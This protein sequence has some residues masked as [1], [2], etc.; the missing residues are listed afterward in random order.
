M[1]IR[2]QV[3][4]TAEQMDSLR[5]MAAA[6]GKSMAEL[7]RQGVDHLLAG[8]ISTTPSDRIARAIAA[9]GRFSSGSTDVSRNHDRYLSDA[10][11]S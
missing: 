11:S 1:L 5:R 2:T 7:I 3:Q 6:S 10:F 9:T 4:L 8:N